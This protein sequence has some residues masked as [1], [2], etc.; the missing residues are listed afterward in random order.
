MEQRKVIRLQ[1]IPHRRYTT[2]FLSELLLAKSLNKFG[3]VENM[4]FT[5]RVEPSTNYLRL[6]SLSHL[7]YRSYPNQ[8][9]A[10]RAEKHNSNLDESL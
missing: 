5:Y 3:F 7:C 4:F 6:R 1:V 10:Q 9:G 2:L 8:E